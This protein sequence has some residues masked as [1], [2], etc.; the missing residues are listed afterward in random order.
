MFPFK[1]PFYSIESGDLQAIF[2]Y[3]MINQQQNNWTPWNARF[4]FDN[5]SI[6]CPFYSYL[7]KLHEIPTFQ[8]YSH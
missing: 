6:V 3:Q 7:F 8:L 1:A 5:L 2:E 4:T